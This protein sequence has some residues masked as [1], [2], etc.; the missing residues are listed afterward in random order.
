MQ[1][2]VF[3]SSCLATVALGAR[4]MIAAAADSAYDL[5]TPTGTIFGTLV[6]PAAA[7]PTPVVLII[8]G[9][10]P[11]DRDGNSPMLKLDIYRKLATVLAQRGIA[12]VRYDK[13]G[14]AA[15]QAALSSELAIRFDTY[16]DDAVAWIK[17]LG[18]DPRFSRVIVVGHSEGSLIGMIAAQRA[19]VDAYVSLEGAG[20]PAATVLATQLQANLPG[21]AGQWQPILNKLS[22]G[23]TVPAADIPTELAPLFR[24]SV[25]PYLI[26]WFK[27]D[28]RVEIAKVSGPVVIV[29][30]THDIQV[31]VPDGQALAAAAPSAKYV[32]IDGMTHVLTDDPGTTPA[33]QAS[34]A[35]LDAARPLDATLV[36][37][38]VAATR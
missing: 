12:S 6:T 33:Q 10:G 28:P 26:S 38:L 34:G 1:R 30:G 29:Q 8:A 5:V 11:T 21:M 23:A 15:S 22:S 16:V 19:H 14:V 13:R 24:A 25:Q 18:A 3:L 37:T 36:T 17:K 31:G 7:P 27:Y 20:F 9:S 32:A 4:P 35:Y 2:Q